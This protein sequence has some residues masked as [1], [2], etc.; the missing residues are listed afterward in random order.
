[1]S[2]TLT[3]TEHLPIKEQ[4]QVI[5][6]GGGVAGC[7]A[8]IQAAKNGKSVLLLEKTNL[9]GGLATIGLVNYFVPMCNGA[10]KQVIFGLADKWFRDSARCGFDTVPDA[11]RDGEPKEPTTVR[12]VNRYSPYL[13]ALHLTEEVLAA[14]VHLLYDVIGTEPVMEGNV[15]RGVIT[16]SKSGRE[17]YPCEMLIDTTGDADLLRRSGIPTAAG[18]NYYT[19]LAQMVTL[20][21]CKQAAES[22]NIR[23]IYRRVC[24]GGIDLY[25]HGQPAHIP[26]W[27]GLRAEEVTDYLLRNQTELLHKLQ[28][29]PKD[30]REL[31]NLPTMPNFRTTC[32]LVGDYSLREQDR[33]R[34]FDDSVCAI[35]DFDRRHFLYEVPLRCLCRRDYPNLLTAGRSASGEGYGWDLLRVIPPAILTGQAAAEAACLALDEGVGA[36]EVP[37]RPLQKR[38]EQSNILIHFPDEWIPQDRETV[39]M[40]NDGHI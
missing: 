19:F 12:M 36:G 25:G 29:I 32:R 27:S 9:L 24:G 3:R 39:E 13:F 35:N 38:L 28:A 8:A 37:I 7:A 4:Y 20:D 34:H 22:G 2:T 6:A 1:M 14:G 5:V 10:G 18:K 31:V 16:E 15:C 30:T 26:Q 11:W 23:D 21:S 17:Y 40:G 33:Y